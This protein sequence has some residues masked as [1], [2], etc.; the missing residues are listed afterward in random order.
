[1]RPY[2]FFITGRIKI[3][4]S[5][6]KIL[7]E[8]T[9]R[10]KLIFDPFLTSKILRKSLT[11]KQFYFE[12]QRK[13]IGF[14]FAQFISVKVLKSA[15]ARSRPNV[16]LLICDDFGIGDFQ[17]YNKNSKVPTP[18]IDR[19]GNEGESFFLKIRE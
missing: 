17:V 4:D 2:Y 6:E 19:L 14:Q 18:N 8:L 11:P 1:M 13:K 3:S 12:D 15:L 7:F 9:L 16:I 5:L 10:L